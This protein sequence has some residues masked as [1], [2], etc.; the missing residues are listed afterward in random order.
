[1]VATQAIVDVSYGPRGLALLKKGLAPGDIVKQICDADP[2]PGLRSKPWP[3]AGRQ[4]AVMDAKGNGHS[5]T[6]GKTYTIDLG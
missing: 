6:C 2:D 1:M 4:F 5:G 3:K